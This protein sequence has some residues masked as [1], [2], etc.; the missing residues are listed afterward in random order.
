MRRGT[1][2]EHTF[3]LPFDTSIIAS[4]RII[5]EQN[6]EEKI[7]K[8]KDDCTF[9]GDVIKVKLTQEDTLTFT[10]NSTIKIQVRILTTD[11][12]AITSDIIKTF[13]YECIDNEVIT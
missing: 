10:C 5:Y 9:A 7:I 4:V 6:D 13:V 2:P 3:T 1:T 11:G 12:E 8:T